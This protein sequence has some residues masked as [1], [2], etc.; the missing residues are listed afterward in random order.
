M[1]QIAFASN[2]A[3]RRTTTKLDMANYIENLTGV[4]TEAAK[5]FF[6]LVFSVLAMRLWRSWVK[7][8]RQKDFTGGLVAAAV[9]LLA[10]TIGYFSM[11]HSLGSLYS[12]YG[13]K[14]FHAGRLPQALALFEI[15]GGYSHR[16]D[17]SGREGVCRLLLGDVE[18]GEAMLAQARASRRGDSQFEDFY[19]GYYWFT[20]GDYN[21]A[22]PWL[23]I[24]YG[25]DEYRW[26]V[27]K[28]FSVM[29]LESNRPAEA[30]NLMQPY[31]QVEVTEPDHAYI[32]AGLKLAGGKK[33]EARALL[34]RFPVTSLSPPWK[35]H[36]EK[37]RAQLSD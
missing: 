1:V 20:Q 32:L 33:A 35:G 24:A 12:S 4:L 30:A 17:I 5:Y 18:K 13:L 19:A 16:A 15:A 25:A 31:N 14:A 10:L 23:R 22:A 36:Y 21:R 6:V 9:T 3:L 8:G 28:L 27:T 29:A 26:T 7:R 34:E 37:M 2:G 11:C